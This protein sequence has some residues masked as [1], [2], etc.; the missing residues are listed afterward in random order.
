[1]LKDFTKE[2]FDV[3]IIAGQSN[4]AGFGY[5]PADEPFTNDGSVFSMNSDL[6]IKYA[7]EYIVG[8]EIQS[9]FSY[10]FVREYI[11][12][13][14]LEEGRKVL[15]LRAAAGGTGFCDNRWGLCDDL[16]LKMIE[17]T[18]TAMSLN[19]NNRLVAL[20]WHQ[21]E[22][23]AMKNV[24]YDVHYNN[25]KNLVADARKRLNAPDL[26]FIAA[27]FAHSW[28]KENAEACEPIINAIKTVCAECGNS[29][30]IETD[31]LLSNL[32]ELGRNPTGWRDVVHFSRNSS[33]KLGKRYFDSF[34]K[35]VG[36][37]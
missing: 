21:G 29:D 11:K 35:I 6:M 34:V 5:G 27:D 23:E 19:K 18:K 36:K 26:P 17:M 24:S 37:T 4:A 3:I 8:N 1:M 7:S 20:L 10:S 12:A 9:G 15:L 30:F 2:E 22:N 32:E 14:L 25:L 13:G 31:G 28:K 33:Y 16:Y